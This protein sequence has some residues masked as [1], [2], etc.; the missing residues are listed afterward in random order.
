MKAKRNW[1][2]VR[3]N[4]A[5]SSNQMTCI[6]LETHTVSFYGH[7]QTK[8]TMI[9]WGCCLTWMHVIYYT[10]CQHVDSEENIL[11]ALFSL[12][13]PQPHPQSMLQFLSIVDISS[14]YRMLSILIAGIRVLFSF[15]FLS[16]IHLF[17]N[18]LAND[19]TKYTTIHGITPKMHRHSMALL[20]CMHLHI[21]THTHQMLHLSI[22]NDDL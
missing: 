12:P 13:S 3:Q 9:T 22:F 6:V 7:V 2:L 18:L 4:G 14:I 1:W 10:V 17:S 5:V 19:D 16:F 15:A 8:I 21:Y 11:H 20:H